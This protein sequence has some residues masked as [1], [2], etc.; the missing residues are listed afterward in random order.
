MINYSDFKS[1]KRQKILDAVDCIYNL[2]AFLSAIIDLECEEAT[3]NPDMDFVKILNEI[4]IDIA[5][6]QNEL[7]FW[8]EDLQKS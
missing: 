1:R 6:M 3:E 2:Q 7:N 5:P 4:K 8:L